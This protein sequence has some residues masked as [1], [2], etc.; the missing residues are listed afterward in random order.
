MHIF[1]EEAQEK[2]GY[3]CLLKFLPHAIQCIGELE[4]CK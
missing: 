4:E 1:H 3:I 2:I